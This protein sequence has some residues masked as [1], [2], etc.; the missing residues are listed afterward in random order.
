MELMDAGSGV[1]EACQQADFGYVHYNH[2]VAHIH[3]PQ[4]PWEFSLVYAV[5]WLRVKVYSVLSFIFI[6]RIWG[7][8][9]R[10]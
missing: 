4:L 8:S 9:G 6:P 3:L 2:I 5:S 1:A 10:L 7:M